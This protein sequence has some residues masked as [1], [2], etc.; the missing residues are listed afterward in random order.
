[1][2]HPRRA[3]MLP[4][5]LSLVV[6]A[7]TSGA[8]SPS[9][10]PTEAASASESASATATTPPTPIPTPTPTAT[11]VVTPH[12]TPT[13]A[14][15]PAPTLVHGQYLLAL[16]HLLGTGDSI[17]PQARLI[18][19][20]G[21]NSHVVASGTM[22]G[23]ASP[24]RYNLSAVWAHNGA[25]IHLVKCCVP[26]LS[27]VSALGGPE[28]PTVSMTNRDQGFVW[29]PNDSKIGY[30]HF[31]SADEICEQNG[32]DEFTA[33]VMVM[34]AN[35]SSKK[36]L[37]HNVDKGELTIQG[38]NHDGT[39]L[40][41]K[42]GTTWELVNISNGSTVGILGAPGTATRLEYSPDGRAIGFI[43]GG[44]AWVKDGLAVFP[45]DLGAATDFAWRPDSAGMVLLGSTLRVVSFFPVTTTT[46]Y[47]GTAV[48]A[49]WSPSGTQI[50]FIKTYSYTGDKIY[51]VAA[52]GGAV[53]AVPGPSHV[54]EVQWQP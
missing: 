11:P 7:C 27:D 41:V 38:W 37:L 24:P 36:V 45:T 33:D 13:P 21:A 19:P 2:L 29:S 34:N 54:R 16:D 26:Q 28:V 50:A 48:R 23:P 6:G 30:W 43:N 15:T 18:Q 40:V 22:V 20:N 35:G 1:M 44:H 52:T 47:A 53:T 12:A 25:T 17:Q 14:P 31:T 42:V 51:V 9:T 10:S 32:S 3:A 4:L 49:T 5:L 46:V 8:S 39:S